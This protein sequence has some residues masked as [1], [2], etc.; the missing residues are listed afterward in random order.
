MTQQ[1]LTVSEHGPM[2]VAP[3]QRP[4][5]SSFCTGKCNEEGAACR[6]SL[7]VPAL[8][9]GAREMLAALGGVG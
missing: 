2:R 6:D 5:Y 7:Q 9:A 4:H 3:L 8:N 1:P